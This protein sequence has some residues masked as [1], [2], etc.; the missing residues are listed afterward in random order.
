MF[1]LSFL[2]SRLNKHNSFN[3]PSEIMFSKA[4]IMLALAPRVSP[5]G[6]CRAQRPQL[7]RPQGQLPHSHFLPCLGYESLINGSHQESCLF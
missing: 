5:H 1:P 4:F 7:R 2:F 3:L 6:E